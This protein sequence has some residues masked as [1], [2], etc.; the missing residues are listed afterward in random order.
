M[1]EGP[2]RLLLAALV[3]GLPIPIGA[4]EPAAA[5]VETDPAARPE[6]HRAA[7]E[8][9]LAALRA[10]LDRGQDPN[11]RDAAGRTPLLEAVAAGRP[12]AVRMLLE[13]GADVAGRTPGGRT[14]LIEAAEQ[15]H[16]QVAEVLIEAGADLDLAQRGWGSALQVAERLGHEQLAALL[17]QAGARSSGRSVGDTV[18]VRPWAGD[19]YCGVVE[20]SRQTSV[21]IRVSEIVGCRKGCAPRAECSAGKPVGGAGLRVGDA[22]ST[23]SWCLTHTGVQP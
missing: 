18:C 16:S 1:L 8:G 9:D 19:G 2:S 12:D 23:V 21:R 11:A 22:I 15:G 13:A 17:L 10:Q 4:Q 20:V 6:L 7:R 14:P 5:R 3:L